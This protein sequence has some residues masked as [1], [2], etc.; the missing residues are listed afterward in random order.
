MNHQ[1]GRRK[2]NIKP[3]HKRS[4]L[5]NQAIQLIMHGH[6][7]STKATIKEVQRFVEKLVTIAR[8]GNSFNN[9]RRVFAQLPYKREAL[10]NLFK[11]IA[12]KYVNRPGGY[13]RVISMGR[14]TSDTAMIARI[15]W[16]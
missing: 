3:S 9:R 15:E 1:N 16:S 2:L 4:L 14:R 8:D 7:T 13:T 5:R 6:V 11:D 10:D 12:P